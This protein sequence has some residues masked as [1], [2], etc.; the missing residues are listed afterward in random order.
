MVRIVDAHAGAK[1]EDDA[2]DNRR[3]GE[4]CHD[5]RK[6]DVVIILFKFNRNENV[7]DDVGDGKRDL[8]EVEEQAADGEQRGD[9]E[10]GRAALFRALATV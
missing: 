9:G 4:R 2:V 3:D 8:E 7:G 10:E 1:D 6:E 5:E